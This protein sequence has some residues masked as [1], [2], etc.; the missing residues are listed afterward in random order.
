M[1]LGAA[2]RQALTDA[3]KGPAWGKSAENPVKQE[4]APGLGR[5][6]F[7]RWGKGGWGKDD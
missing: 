1:V 2:V 7:E 3:G 4:V 6:H 5:L